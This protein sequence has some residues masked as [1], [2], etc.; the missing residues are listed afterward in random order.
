MG[1]I[2]DALSPA[3]NVFGNSASS[4]GQ[5]KYLLILAV[6][7]AV[8]IGIG[9]FVREVKN[10]KKQW[11]H[12]IKVT[13]KLLDGSFTKEVIHNCRRFPLQ[14]GVE[15]FELEKPILGSYL[16]PQP[17]KYVD[18][19]TFSIILDEH[20]RI[21]SNNGMKFNKDTQSLEVSAVHAGIDVEMH[22]MKER[23][24]QAH[25]I[26][27]KITTAEL[28]KAGLKAMM[29]IA[30]TIISIIAIGEWGDSQ[31]AR[32]EKAVQEAL[33]MENL[34]HALETMEKTV[35]TQQLQLVPMLRAMYETD[36][37]APYIQKYCENT[38]EEDD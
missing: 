24:Q 19:N 15:V 23:W 17:S 9:A 12:K 29:I 28:I 30:I 2:G 14:Q 18:V 1:T 26:N 37:I 35:N 6:V 10:K 3:M 27:K 32:A 36:N 4:I 31:Q 38:E 25:T 13:R 8:I 34:N 22:T 20:N 21:W 5:M 7:V 11:T 33:A 16:I